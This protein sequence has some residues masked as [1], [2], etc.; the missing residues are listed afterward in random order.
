MACSCEAKCK[1]RAEMKERHGDPRSFAAAVW[2]A[3]DMVTP[4]E[5]KDAIAKYEREWSDTPNA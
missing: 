4:E 3:M 2:N 5:A 1:T